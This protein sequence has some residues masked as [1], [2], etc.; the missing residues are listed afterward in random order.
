MCDELTGCGHD[1]HGWDFYRDTR[2]LNGSVSVGNRTYSNPSPSTLL[3]RPDRL[4]AR[5]DIEPGVCSRLDAFRSYRS[6][7][8]DIVAFN[9]VHCGCHLD[10][11]DFLL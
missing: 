9:P 4:T 8:Q 3:W 11:R 2:V 6:R 5:Y 1:L 10:V 7:V